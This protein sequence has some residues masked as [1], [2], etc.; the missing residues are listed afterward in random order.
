MATKHAY[1]LV[2]STG[3]YRDGNGNTKKKWLTIG[4]MYANEKGYFCTLEPYINL[5][6]IP[7][8]DRGQVMVSCFEPK[9][10]TGSAPAGPVPSRAPITSGGP[11]NDFDDDIPF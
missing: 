6:G 2:V 5:A 4:R 3:E 1:D 7:L 8:S 9:N 10:N 11:L